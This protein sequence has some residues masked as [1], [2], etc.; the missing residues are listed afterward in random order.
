MA[1]EDTSGRPLFTFSSETA[2]LIKFLSV[3]SVVPSSCG[4]CNRA[5]HNFPTSSKYNCKNLETAVVDDNLIGTKT[6]TCQKKIELGYSLQADSKPSQ[7]T[8]DKESPCDSESG[9]SD[10]SLLQNCGSPS[11]NSE[12]VSHFSSNR[13]DTKTEN[14]DDSD[15]SA[16]VKPKKIKVDCS[17]FGAVDRQDTNTNCSACCSDLLSETLA[18]SSPDCYL[19]ENTNQKSR[20]GPLDPSGCKHEVESSELSKNLIFVTGEFA[21]ALHQLGF[22]NVPT[23]N[24]DSSRRRTLSESNPSDGYMVVNYSNNDIHIVQRQDSPDK[25]DN[26]IDLFGHVTG[27][28]LSKDQR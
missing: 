9:A 28:C 7:L 13:T 8:L 3:A 26:L 15:S 4:K 17:D 21:V 10:S 22:K 16:T 5:G 2:S 24:E 20:T 14:S 25:P 18:S 23:L 1:V 6:C 12:D 19:N 11:H 27:L